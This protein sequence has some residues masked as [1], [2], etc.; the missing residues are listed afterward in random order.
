MKM[1][2]ENKK[3]K[4]LAGPYVIDFDGET[5]T[6]CF[7]NGKEI[8][9][10]VDIKQKKL[11]LILPDIEQNEIVELELT[12]GKF[13]GS[14]VKFIDRPEKGIL[15]IMIGQEYFSS[16]HYGN[17][18]VR[19]FLN[20]LITVNGKSVLR[21]P[22]AEGNPEKLDHI[23]HRGLWVAHGDI[24]GV[25]N[26][27]ETTGHGWT[28]HQEFIEITSGPVFGRLHAKSFWMD[29]SKTKKICEEERIITVYNMPASARI[30]DHFTILRA[31]EGELIF[32][33]TKESGLLSIRVMPSM[34]ANQKGTLENSIGGINED[35]CW[36]KRAQWCDYYGPVDDIV[37]GISVF[38]HPANLRY[39]TWWHIRNYGLFSANFFGLSE[40]TGDKKISGTYILPACQ[41]M[42]LFYRIYVHQGDTR[43][44]MVPARYLNFLYPAQAS[45][46]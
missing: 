23:H 44:A 7:F 39:P 25:D 22:V 31:S 37:V 8:P 32:R 28:V 12:A 14:E 9:S 38:D 1:R 24:N 27:S 13:N 36:G 17:N 3:R 16:Y 26:W 21:P 40:F 34:Q 46:I 29:G 20:P 19:P 15:D 2:I 35:E 18:V 42:K 43:Q 4:W 30:I 11:A 10:Q 5:E 6:K 45:K 41:E 33:D